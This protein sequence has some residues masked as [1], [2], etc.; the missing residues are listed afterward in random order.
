[1]LY[2]LPRK[3]KMGQAERMAA[4]AQP[5]DA[6]HAIATHPE[7]AMEILNKPETLAHV[8]LA[9]L[10][11][12]IGYASSKMTQMRPFRTVTMQ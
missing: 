9:A 7:V 10:A 4:K 11:A 3:K 6:I 5:P 12:E 1:M 8:D 2:E